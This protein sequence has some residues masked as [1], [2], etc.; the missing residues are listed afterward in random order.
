LTHPFK[1]LFTLFFWYFGL[2]DPLVAMNTSSTRFSYLRN[3]TSNESWTLVDLGSHK[4]EF[5][6]RATIHLKVNRFIFV[7]PNE[8]YNGTLTSKYPGSTILNYGVS[9]KKGFLSYV[10]NNKNPGQNLTSEA[11][12]GKEKVKSIS[13][14]K[15]MDLVLHDQNK[16]FLK[17]D[18]EGHEISNLQTLPV[19]IIE[20]ISV[21]SIEVTPISDSDDF[22][23]RLNE[24]V[25]DYFDFYRERRFG[26]VP[27]NRFQPHWTDNL[28]L[29][30]NIILVNKQII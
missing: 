24:I 9:H 29:F 14:E 25:P 18:I 28:N 21:I 2:N 1:K 26:W 11:Q 16:I 5:A 22:L 8:E 20:K 17:M 4:G 10:R 6:D 7:D 23:R 13:L 3:F 15:V 27:I 30:Q 19:G 12:I